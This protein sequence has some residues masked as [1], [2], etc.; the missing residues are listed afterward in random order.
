MWGSDHAASLGTSGVIKLVR[1][2]R[3]VEMSLGDGVKRV[4]EKE[5]SII[6]KLRRKGQ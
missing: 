5:I 4:I 2:I 6:S 3:L 1:D